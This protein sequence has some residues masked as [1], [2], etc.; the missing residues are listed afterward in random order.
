MLAGCTSFLPARRPTPHTPRAAFLALPS[1][2]QVAHYLVLAQLDDSLLAHITDNV[3]TLQPV[4]AEVFQR[5]RRAA[6]AKRK[7]SNEA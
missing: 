2:Q 7:R 3:H 1:P 5:E 6:G 4:L